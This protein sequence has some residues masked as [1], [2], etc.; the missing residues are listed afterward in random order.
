MMDWVH[1]IKTRTAPSGVCSYPVT[2]N[3]PINA[4]I[5]CFNDLNPDI[6]ETAVR[7]DF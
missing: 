1:V 7:F 5:A 4:P 2:G 3:A 6:L